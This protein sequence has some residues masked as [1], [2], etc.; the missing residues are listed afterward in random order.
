M[1][2]PLDHAWRVVA[3][4]LAFAFIFVGGG[5]L[6]ATVLP[7][8]ALWPGDSRQRSQRV[9]HLTFRFYLATLQAIRLLRLETEGLDRLA[10]S[11]GAIVVANHPSLL[12]VVMLMA[13]IPRAHCIVKHQLWT[14]RLLGGLVRRAGYIRNDLDGEQMVA[15]CRENL[16]RG[17]AL[18][19]FPEGTRSR[20]GA[21]LRFQ[22]GFAT[23]AVLTGAPVL[24]VLITCDPPTLTKGE[25]WWTVPARR[26]LFRLLVGA[27]LDTAA[28]TGSAPRALA[29][30]R[31]TRGLEQQYAIWLS[32][33]TSPPPAGVVTGA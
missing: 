4:G 29:A 14:S 2:R 33:Q 26:P 16:A 10:D 11:G 31:L 18:I 17:T 19:V 30:R 32:G 1:L 24:P 7:C 8:L 27:R 13:F 3:T 22:R 9:I 5:L 23:L 25:A 21:P 28:L 20:P 12:D 6:A 15:A